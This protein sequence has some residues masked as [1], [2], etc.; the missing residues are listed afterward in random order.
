L[1]LKGNRIHVNGRRCFGVLLLAASLAACAAPEPLPPGTPAF[2]VLG[3]IPYSEHEVERL[4][5]LIDEMNA[6]ELAFVV[7]VGDIGHS[8]LA[9]A[10]SDDWLE[11]RKAQFARIR[12]RFILLPG[13]NEWSDCARH[14]ID[15]LRRLA[16]WR[17]LFCVT[18]REFCEHR[19]WEAGGWVFVTLNVPGSNNNLR[20][21]EHG[22]RMKAVFAELDAAAKLAEQ[23][24]GLVILLHAN[25]FFYPR[26][27]DGYAELKDRLRA[28]AARM[29]GKV[30]LIHGDTHIYRD[31][32][33]LPGL[34]RLEVWGSPFV[35]WLRALI[36]GDGLRVDSAR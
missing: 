16:K 9:Q 8:T 7:H 25:P 11:K 10:C 4:D 27:R 23:R 14:G 6:Q 30:V 15:P 3:D 24:A 35:G 20:H 32:E 13:D 29:P 31:D 19:R 18:T 2:G 5:R 1:S 34:R 22:P 12:H 17:Q 26:P 33:P 36:Q 21:A 28:L